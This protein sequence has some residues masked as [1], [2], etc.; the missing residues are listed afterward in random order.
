MADERRRG[1]PARGGPK[2]TQSMYLSDDVI[3]AAK[4]LGEGWNS[5]ID[6][7]LRRELIE[8]HGKER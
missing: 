5:R 2:S 3:A 4:A 7:I 8:R 1:R 6:E